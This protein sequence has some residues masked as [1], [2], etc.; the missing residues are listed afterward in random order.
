MTS[1]DFYVAV[2]GKDTDAGTAAAPFA[3][4]ARA[5]EAVREKIRAGLDKDILVRIHAG[6]YPV[7]ETLTFGPADSGT[8]TFS[9]TYAAAPGEK[10]VLSG[11]RKIGGWKK[12]ANE[13][14]TAEVPEVKEGK[15][16]LRSPEQG[17][18]GEG[19]WYP[20]Q[21]FVPRMAA[22]KAL[23]VKPGNLDPAS[24]Y[25]LKAY[26]GPVRRTP[27]DSSAQDE[28]GDF[29]WGP[30]FPMVHEIETASDPALPGAATGRELMEN[31]MTLKDG[32]VAVWVVYQRGE[33]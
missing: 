6:T 14:W 13:I 10:V 29:R 3:T 21:L 11:G 25:T 24:R 1:A 12:G 33:A 9:I 28:G 2:S 19:G 15:P 16:A 26:A 23:V 20:R 5:R 18:G 27:T 7:L 4:L 30:L 8:E 32:N 31:G 17:R 22:G